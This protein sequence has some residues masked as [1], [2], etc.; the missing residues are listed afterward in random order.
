[1]EKN[2]VRIITYLPQFHT[3]PYASI[4]LIGFYIPPYHLLP[5]YMSKG[6][7]DKYVM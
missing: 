5:T 2:L 4:I 1:M 3:N 6:P 7:M